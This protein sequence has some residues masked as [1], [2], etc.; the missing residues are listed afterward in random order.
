M[1]VPLVPLSE[2]LV[3]KRYPVKVVA[4]N[5]YP[6]IG[7]LNVG[8]GSFKRADLLG[9]S[10]KYQTLFQVRSAQVI[11][12][13]LKAFEGAIAVVPP[14]HDGHYV[15]SEFPTFSLREGISPEYLAHVLR[16]EQ[17]TKQ[18]RHVS[19]GVG[20]RRERVHPRDFLR[21][22]IP[23][24]DFG[25]QCAIAARLDSIV[26]TVRQSNLHMNESSVLDSLIDSVSTRW[27]CDVHAHR[28]L[29]SLAKISRGKSLR[30]DVESNVTA[31]GQASVRWSLRPSLFK[32]VDAKWAA[33]VAP[34]DRTQVGELLV[35]STGEGTIGRAALVDA[36]AA[37]LLVDSHILRVATLD[38][39]DAELILLYLWSPVGRR[40]IER[41]KGSTT[42]KQ[43]EL[44]IRRLSLLL[45]PDFSHEQKAQYRRELTSLYAASAR[46]HEL[47]NQSEL[48][49][50]ALPQAARNAEFA[51]LMS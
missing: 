30:L 32:G 1:S 13:K 18:L 10:T 37:G 21:L 5:V 27:Q 51:R 25:R 28:P 12:S 2:V 8:R 40:A 11:F 6:T 47:R 33:T 23:L 42:T 46:Y 35:N 16:S 45:I 38:P 36:A 9:A 41:L 22:R 31:I 34:A 20:A 26:E 14:E 3:E 15:S 17:F 4:T 24:P 43:T 48:L 49:L 44:G 19:R 7:V 50:K 29:H 39:N